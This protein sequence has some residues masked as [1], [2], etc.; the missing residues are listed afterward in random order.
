MVTPPEEQA[1]L[2]VASELGISKSDAARYLM[3]LGL[4]VH[5]G[6]REGDTP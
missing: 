2:R 3:N 5:H 1:V 4:T 6:T